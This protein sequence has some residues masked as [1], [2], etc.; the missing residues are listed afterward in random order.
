VLI[1]MGITK[2]KKTDEEDAGTFSRTQVQTSPVE[3]RTGG[4]TRP[5]DRGKQRYNSDEIYVTLVD[6][7]DPR[8]RYTA[9][10][11]NNELSIGRGGVDDR[12]RPVAVDLRIDT[13]DAKLSRKHAVFQMKDGK[14]MVNDCSTNGI[15]IGDSMRRIEMPTEI[16]QKTVLR[17]GK[18]KFMVTW[19]VESAS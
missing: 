4:Y 7:D 15:F 14:M 2:K 3:D 1:I 12:G 8:N 6:V 10:M 19:T 9:P 17:M 18:V 16:H 5:D 11:K 13:N